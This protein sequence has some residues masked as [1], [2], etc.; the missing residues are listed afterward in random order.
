[1][2][3]LS[4]RTD[5]NTRKVW[6]NFAHNHPD[7]VWFYDASLQDNALNPY[8]AFLASSKLIF[9]TEES[10]NMLT[11]AYSTPAPVYRLKMAGEAGKF[12]KL[13]DKLEALRDIPTLDETL[14]A[15]ETLYEPLRET[16]RIAAHVWDRYQQS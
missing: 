15:S 5:S 11:E 1:M 13:Y 7:H 3:T 14:S 8:F 4:R 9:V 10:T 12:Q 2:I 16:D 6:E